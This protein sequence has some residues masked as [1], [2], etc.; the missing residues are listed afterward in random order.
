MSQFE[1][2]QSSVEL[3]D[4][5]KAMEDLSQDDILRILRP[6]GNRLVEAMKATIRNR[7]TRRTG[8][9]E[10]SIKAVNKTDGDPYILVAPDG[11]H[12]IY[13][14]VTGRGRDRKITRKT[15]TAA[16]V[17]FVLE[18]GRS[19]VPATHWMEQTITDQQD[20]M[21]ADMQAALD[22]IISERTETS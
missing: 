4:A 9:L 1:P 13:N 17:A 20:A 11:R 2:L 16:E 8:N 19:G 14:H 12:H 15:A 22:E 10:S 5:L 3:A 7:F 6:A 21:S 18:Y